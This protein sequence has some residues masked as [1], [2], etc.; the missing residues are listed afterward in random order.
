MNPFTFLHWTFHQLDD[1]LLELVPDNGIILGHDICLLLEM[2][3]QAV[4]P[5]HAQLMIVR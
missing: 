3:Q 4:K 2:P 1:A 5:S